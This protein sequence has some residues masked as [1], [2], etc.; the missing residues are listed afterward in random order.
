MEVIE[1][2]SAGSTVSL[3]DL[4]WG[5][6]S[7]CY[8]RPLRITDSQGVPLRQSLEEY[9]LM[10]AGSELT[11]PVGEVWLITYIAAQTPDIPIV[12]PD[13]TTYNEE[14]NQCIIT[15]PVVFSCSQ[16]VFDPQ[17]Q[18]CVIQPEFRII[19]ELGSYNTELEKCVYFV[20]ENQTQIICPAGSEITV[21]PEGI[22][23]C[24]YE[25]ESVYICEAGHLDLSVEPPICRI[26]PLVDETVITL[27]IIGGVNAITFIIIV[28]SGM[29]ILFSSIVLIVLLRRKK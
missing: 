22:T 16:G 18:V 27:P 20:P 14:D 3:Q 17:Q 1:P 10:Q 8:Q 7:F 23:K 15:P 24:V 4:R 12:C 21:T 19:C 2:Y 5:F 6:N 13:G 26:N 11:V 9:A 28:V 29:A 25:G